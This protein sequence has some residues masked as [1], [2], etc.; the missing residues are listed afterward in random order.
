MDNTLTSANVIASQTII[1]KSSAQDAI[2]IPSGLKQT[3][4]TMFWCLFKEQ[5]SFLSCKSQIFN[6]LSLDPETNRLVWIEEEMQAV[7]PNNSNLQDTVFE[8]QTFIVASAEAETINSPFGEN[9][10]HEIRSLWPIKERK[11]Y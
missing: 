4:F 1:D 7:W 5:I 9:M 10:A 6:V 8:H 3:E 11:T 2:F